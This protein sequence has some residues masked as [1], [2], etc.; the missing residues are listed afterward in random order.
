MSVKG[1]YERG[2]KR[3]KFN[4]GKKINLREQWDLER[5]D[6]EHE[7]M[8]RDFFAKKAKERKNRKKK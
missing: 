4:Y 6:Q 2:K 3:G 7:R 5:K 1:T 8:V